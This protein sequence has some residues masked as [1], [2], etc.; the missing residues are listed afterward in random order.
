[1]K[2]TTTIAA[3]A[4]AILCGAT[5]AAPNLN[6]ASGAETKTT[7][8]GAENAESILAR[9]TVE[10]KVG[11]MVCVAFRN[12]KGEGRRGEVTELNAALE[13]AIA[14]YRLGGICL[15]AQ[16][17]EGTEQTVRLTDQIQTAARKSRL[18][19]TMLITVD[20]E[21]GYVARF[22]TGTS[23]PGNMAL[24]ATRDPKN[25]EIVG[26]IIGRE[27]IAMG[28]NANFGPVLDVND[29][30][31]NPIIG[32]RSFSDD[33]DVV[34][35]F[36][37]AYIAGLHSERAISCVKHFPGHGD[38]DVDS[39]S[40]FPKID[41]SFDELMKT[42]LKPFAANAKTTDMTMTAHIQ[43]PQVETETYASIKTGEKVNLPA[44]LSK[45][46]VSDVLRDK[47]G[48]DGVVCTDSLGMAAISANFKPMDSAKLA[49]L[50]DVDILLM[51][52][53]VE[54]EA[55]IERLGEY[56]SGVVDMVEKG[57][58]PESELD[59]SVLRILK[60]KEKYGILDPPSET[61][62][63]RIATALGVVG[64][65]AS[66][67]AEWNVALKAIV[68][69]RNDGAFPVVLQPNARVLWLTPNSSLA[70]SARYA[71]DRLKSEGKIPES[72][73]LETVNY[74]GAEG[75]DAAKKA[76]ERAD[77]VLLGTRTTGL[78][79]LD[80]SDPENVSAVFVNAAIKKARKLGKKLAIVSAHL[81]Y[82]AAYYSDADAAYLAF[83]PSGM[84]ALPVTFDGA[85]QKYGVNVPAAVY[86]A[87]GGAKPTGA[88][89]VK[90][91]VFK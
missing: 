4:L 70:L 65:K 73:V 89:P 34:A 58:I 44:T 85:T 2:N 75:K 1:M 29:N 91:D 31:N 50:A 79:M 23:T 52:V 33:P 72:T 82:D 56:L 28:F 25:A 67:D 46:I 15:F 11:Q 88:S 87:L 21:G 55:G 5:F 41:K 39:H 19:V 18:G 61:L 37:A 53:V 47:L 63:K 45:T 9:M 43:F 80:D 17:C 40:G 10:D 22:N 32:V 36:G 48:F 8:S 26:A 24:A 62:D 69:Y 59:D 49:I 27:L 38:T 76:I 12:W 51:P 74:S 13:D 14:K 16:N 78:D 3:L 30:P 57:E 83:N 64:C 90:V 71:V 7:D 60:M 68:E 66:H 86:I 81:P 84:S 35:R 6:G 54:D 20:Q 42:E 77:V